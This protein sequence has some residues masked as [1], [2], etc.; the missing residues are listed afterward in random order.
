MSSKRYESEK[1]LFD[2]ELKDQ[3]FKKMVDIWNLKYNSVMADGTISD[4][5][6]GLMLIHPDYRIRHTGEEFILNDG[7]FIRQKNSSTKCEW[8]QV[9]DYECPWN[10]DIFLRG[11][12]ELDHH[13][14]KS[15]GGPTNDSNRLHLCKHHNSCKSNSIDKYTW[16]QTPVWLTPTLKEIYEKRNWGFN[17]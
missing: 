2:L 13:W 3:S 1:F 14:P 16:N 5:V 4:P 9:G 15:L 6:I 11:D 17:P 12:L 7:R 8:K 10:Q